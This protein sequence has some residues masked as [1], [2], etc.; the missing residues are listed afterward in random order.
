MHFTETKLSGAFLIDPEK[1]EDER[2]F[3]ALSWSQREFMERGL[4]PCLVECNVSFNKSK[5]T[6]RGMHYQASPHAQAKVVRC[7]RGAVFDVIIDLRAE[8]ATFHQWVGVELTANNCRLLYV[9]EGFAHGFQTLVDDTEIFYQ[10][11]E[12][13]APEAGRGVRWDD[14]AFGIEWP[15]AD[16]RIINRRDRSHP[17]VTPSA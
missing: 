13:Y 4:N 16:E 14:P 15:A 2:G 6:L 3:F 8:S 11:A 10:M 5:H 12:Y 17:P 7:T 1:F 9:P